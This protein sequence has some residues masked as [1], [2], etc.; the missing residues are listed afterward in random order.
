MPTTK[1]TVSIIVP[2]LNAGKNLSRCIESAM[3]QTLKTIEILLIISSSDQNVINI[4]ERYAKRDSRIKIINKQEVTFGSACNSGLA[5]ASGEY[6]GFVEPN[7]WIDS[8]MYEEL[9]NQA[10]RHNSDVVK[11]LYF[12]HDA[13]D[14]NIN[15]DIW[16]NNRLFDT[17]IY[18]KFLLPN[19]YLMG[20]SYWSAIYKRDFI[21]KNEISFNESLNSSVAQIGFVFLVFCYMSSIFV[22]RTAFYHY[23]HAEYQSIN[24][25]YINAMDMLNEHSY[26]NQEINKRGINDRAVDL[27]VARAFK[28]IFKYY[29]KSCNSTRQ[30]VE[31]L[32]ITSNL[33][34]KFLPTI[35][36]N[37]YLSSEEKHQLKQIVTHPKISA[38]FSKRNQYI[39]LILLLVDVKATKSVKR[40]KVFNFPVVFIKTTSD[41]KTFNIC[42]LPIKRVKRSINKGEIKTK[43]YYLWMPLAKRI[44]TSE[45]IKKYFLGFRTHKEINIQAQLTSLSNRINSLPTIKDIFYYSNLSNSVAHVHQQTFP[46]FKNSNKGKAIA[47]LATGPTLNYAPE[48][49]SVKTI[50]CNRSFEFLQEKGLEPDYIFVQD[51]PAVRIFFHEL[52]KQRSKIFIGQYPGRFVNTMSTPEYLRDQENVYNYYTSGGRTYFTDIRPDIECNTLSDHGTI[53]HPALHF[54]LYTNPDKIFLIGCDT[55][56]S[57]YFNKN[58]VQGTM[59]VDNLIVGYKKFKEFSNWHYPN[60]KI[61]S[62]NPIG[63]KGLFDEDQYTQKYLEQHAELDSSDFKIIDSL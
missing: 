38:L 51:Y 60:T 48:L 20:P 61:I 5:A 1:I 3:S 16:N 46:Q 7:D 31:Y 39:R 4:C 6:I 37:R 36:A 33:L 52:L 12:C 18:D 30:R 49:L 25:N 8:G 43:Y 54:A 53:V 13:N 15:S 50:C 22:R 62:I 44:D 57:G 14:T 19:F 45:E 42:N 29:K 34:K 47:I 27:E 23:N 11:S 21:I 56:R 40:I 32:K 2:V 26:I 28:D 17:K 55:S 59:N 24:N 10:S 58:L 35:N 63:L 9:Y 41:Y